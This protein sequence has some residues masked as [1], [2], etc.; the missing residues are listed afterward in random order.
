[1]TRKIKISFLLLIGCIIVIQIIINRQDQM[2]LREKS[3]LN[4]GGKALKEKVV[5]AFSIISDE[6]MEK[7]IKGYGYFGSMELSEKIKKDMLSS[8]AKK[9]DVENGYSVN[10]ESGAGFQKMIL[11]KAGK[12]KNYNI[13]IV[14]LQEGEEIPEQYIFVEILTLEDENAASKLFRKIQNVYHEIGVEQQNV[15]MEIIT[16][17]K[18]NLE[19]ESDLRENEVKDIFKKWD[20]KEVK[21]IDNEDMHTVYGYTSQMNEYTFVEGKKANVQIVFSYVEAENKTYIKIGI[22]IVNSSY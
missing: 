4:N 7:T 14:S 9:L 3:W 15:N 10:E 5:T 13:Q 8:L 1:M 2:M 21:T 18:G 12:E 16:K 20:A 17:K 19:N 11:S 6:E 22:P